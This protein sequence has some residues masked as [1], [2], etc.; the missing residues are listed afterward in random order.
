MRILRGQAVWRVH[1]SAQAAS[2][3]AD[4]DDQ[5]QGGAEAAPSTAE[6]VRIRTGPSQ[7][8]R[9]VAFRLFTHSHTQRHDSRALFYHVP[10]LFHKSELF[11]PAGPGEG[12][13]S[14]RGANQSGISGAK[15]LL[16]KSRIAAAAAAAAADAT[17]SAPAT[18]AR[19]SPPQPPLPSPPPAMVDP[20]PAKR[21]SIDK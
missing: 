1:T 12:R 5:S 21:E 16:P 10:Q 14:S 18:V 20:A 13:P 4:E 2:L 6:A 9:E 11:D 15:C 7:R 17:H 8:G 3:A 19:P